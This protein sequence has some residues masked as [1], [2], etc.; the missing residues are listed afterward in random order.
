MDIKILLLVP[1]KS[2]L[3]A[4]NFFRDFE[5]QSNKW[6]KLPPFL[7]P[8]F[9]TPIFKCRTQQTLKMIEK[10]KFN[11]VS[12]ASSKNYSSFEI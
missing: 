3:D 11:I 5:V 2:D 7:V 6:K 12:L 1:G 9:S 8:S 10:E 4:N